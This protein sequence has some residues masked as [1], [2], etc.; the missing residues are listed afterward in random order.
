MMECAVS[1]TQLPDEPD[2][3]DSP[4]YLVYGQV[5]E[6]VTACLRAGQ[7]P[8]V[9]A[10]VQQH[11]E[12]AAQIRELVSALMVMQQVDPGGQ[13]APDMPDFA[14]TGQLGD[15]RLV[16]EVGRGGMGIVYEAEQISLRRRVALKVLPF[17]AVLDPRALQ[18]FKNEAQ[19]AAS[20]HHAH[21]VPVYAVGCERGVHY[22]AMQFIDGQSLEGLI[23]EL[24]QQQT[25][26]ETRRQGDKE[27]KKPCP[28]TARQTAD[29]AA[30]TASLSP[31]LLVSLSPFFRTVAQL[32]W[33]AA[34]ALEHAHQ[35][36]VVHRDIKPAN[37]LV[38]LRGQLWVADFGLARCQDDTR[39]TQ[40][41]DLV[42]TIR[43]MSPEQALAKHGLVDHRTD[44]Y[45]LGVTLYELLT[46]EPA[47]TGQD[48]HE[49]LWRIACEEP[50][51]PRHLN[52]AIPAELETIILKAIAKDP[53]ER[54][55]TAQELADDLRR[56][57]EDRPIRATRPT[58]LERAQRWT[59][60][61]TQ[62]VLLTTALLGLALLGLVTSTLMIWHEKTQKERM[63]HRAFM[64]ADEFYTQVAETWLAHEPQLEALQQEFL[65]KALRFYQ[66]V[67]QDH[68]TDPAVRLKTARAYRRV[69]DIQHKLEQPLEAEEAYRQALAF[70]EPLAGE[71]TT[72]ADARTELALTYNGLGGLMR[73]L[74]RRAEAVQA[75]HQGLAL[76]E[77][78]TAD[79]PDQLDYQ[80]GLAGIRNNLGTVLQARRRLPEAEMAYRQA[81]V[82]FEKLARAHP[83][84]AAYQ[85]DLATSQNNLATLLRDTGRLPEAETVQCQALAQWEKLKTAFPGTPAYWQ[86]LAV[87]AHNLGIVLAATGRSQEAEKVY[88]QALAVRS[89]LR[90]DFPRVPLY[91]QELASSQHHLGR[92]LLAQG[93]LA[94]AEAAYREAWSLR[95]QLVQRGEGTTYRL[96]LARS[97]HTLCLLL[98]P[99]G[100]LLEAEEFYQQGLALLEAL[101]PTSATE[102][103]FRRELA[104]SYH[105][106]GALL[107]SAGQLAEADQAYERAAAI[108]KEPNTDLTNQRGE[109]T[110]SD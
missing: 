54:Y 50:R 102:P 37:L 12:L 72:G 64:A 1:P 60:R 53:A 101:G 97:C 105:A 70:L 76:F 47:I 8:D 45:S 79:H 34:E 52:P 32:G 83:E 75:Y 91:R 38:D 20:L 28:L 59:R 48:R 94:E 30:R 55:L 7:T 10:L 51:P 31:C 103:E 106:L 24:R 23:R 33:Q 71:G 67:V 19:A 22:Y 63:A 14:P 15:Y 26:K 46:L 108:E 62:A 68:G 74:G 82:L 17:A 49:L 58:L 93:R 57:C 110:P 92:L 90:S 56:F 9:E 40:T 107:Q 11:P 86:G 3:G 41:G 100:R 44:V 81:Q 5:A 85:Q 18:R 42:G 77:K 35:V 6:A 96:E 65:L 27:T 95:E 109:K 84:T 104:H 36:G 43:Y 4:E 98:A 69:G 73:L 13:P 88:R 99:I 39:V 25:D 78:L 61:H 21:I 89:R 2:D 16:R 66:E 87:C 29:H 80:D